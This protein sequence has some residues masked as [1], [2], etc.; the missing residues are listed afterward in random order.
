QHVIE[1]LLN[2]RRFACDVER[3]IFLTVLHRLF[4]PGSDRAADKWR[5]D[6]FYCNR[7]NESTIV[8]LVSGC[9]RR[10]GNFPVALCQW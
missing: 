5:T 10:G 2:G 1:Q 6:Y 7:S 4:D 8:Q 9:D 3:A